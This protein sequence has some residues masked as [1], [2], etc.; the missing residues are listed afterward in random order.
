MGQYC[1]RAAR[2]R[3]GTE[4][5]EHGQAHR[6]QT[7]GSRCTQPGSSQTQ[8]AQRLVRRAQSP[9]RPQPTP[10]LPRPGRR[11]VQATEPLSN[12]C[13]DFPGVSASGRRRPGGAR[14]PSPGADASGRPGLS[15]HLG[16]QPDATRWPCKVSSQVHQAPH[17]AGAPPR[18]RPSPQ[19]ATPVTLKQCLKLQRSTPNPI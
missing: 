11:P 4:K 18:L 5:K 10:A 17:R 19:P 13:F 6:N 15:S 8:S 3:A 2:Q 14:I 16:R 12:H 7:A 9:P 1:G